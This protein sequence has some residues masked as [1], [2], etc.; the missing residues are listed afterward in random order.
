LPLLILEV[1]MADMGD[2]LAWAGLGDQ[3]P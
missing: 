3:I 1:S 2:S